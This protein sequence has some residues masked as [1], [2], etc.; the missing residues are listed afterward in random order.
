MLVVFPA[1]ANLTSGSGLSGNERLC[2]GWHKIQIFRAFIGR[3]GRGVRSSMRLQ[4]SSG[5]LSSPSSSNEGTS[6]LIRSRSRPRSASLRR[7][8]SRRRG[9]SRV[10]SA[11]LDR[12]DKSPGSSQRPKTR[13]YTAKKKSRTSSSEL[14]R[15]ELKS[16]QV[17]DRNPTRD[18]RR[19]QLRRGEVDTTA[20]GGSGEGDDV[21]MTVSVTCLPQQRCKSR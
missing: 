13:A 6:T 19:R 3:F 16:S 1:K 21:T 4:S 5:V 14:K 2:G 9:S 11:S 10:R 12:P 20:S 18:W 7:S 15:R 8:S 17:A